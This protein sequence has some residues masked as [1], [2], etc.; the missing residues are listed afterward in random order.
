[1]DFHYLDT[2]YGV[3]FIFRKYQLIRIKQWLR[4]KCPITKETFLTRLWSHKQQI[5]HTNSS[6]FHN[7][8][9]ETFESCCSELK[10]TQLRCWLCLGSCNV[11]V[12][13]R[14]RRSP[15]RCILDLCSVRA[16]S[17]V[18]LT[19]FT[20]GLNLYSEMARY[21]SKEFIQYC[22]ASPSQLTRTTWICW[23]CYC[24]IQI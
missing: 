6:S 3:D 17:L 1:M 18:F 15:E 4:A 22:L 5:H 9:K 10:M 14:L 8:F 24:L 21:L 12:G 11:H 13:L 16:L 19:D 23:T 20:A 2:W 7:C